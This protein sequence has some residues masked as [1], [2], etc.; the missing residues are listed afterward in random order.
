VYFYSLSE[1]A[2]LFLA[3]ARYRTIAAAIRDI[4]F[5]DFFFTHLQPTSR[6]LSGGAQ[7]ARTAGLHELL[8]PLAAEFP[9]ASP[10]GREL[11]FLQCESTPFV[12]HERVGSQLLYAGT[13]REPFRAD[14]F[15]ASGDGR[16]FHPIAPRNFLHAGR[17]EHNALDAQQ[18]AANAV[19][20]AAPAA[21][22]ISTLALC[23]SAVA[24][25]FE[26][27]IQARKSGEHA[28]PEAR[29]ALA[30]LQ[31]VHPLTLQPLGS[32]YESDFVLE[33]EGRRHV[34]FAL[35]LGQQQRDTEHSRNS[36]EKKGTPQN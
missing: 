7:A 4:K 16:L 3:N 29:A 20:G 33:W 28:A 26:P 17:Q 19:E 8:A 31:L 34:I 15:F 12:F 35:E 18:P 6:F 24:V 23:R 36:R 13:L 14:L 21:A 9:F 32:V 30:S 5:L 22:T 25:T 27:H 1:S 11:N 2:L 10:C